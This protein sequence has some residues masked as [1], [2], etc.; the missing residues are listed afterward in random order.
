MTL[1]RAPPLAKVAAG[2]PAQRASAHGVQKRGPFGTGQG[3]GPIRCTAISRS[4]I[5]SHPSWMPIAAYMFGTKGSREGVERPREPEAGEAA[6]S[7][8]AGRG[9][10]KGD[11]GPHPP[12]TGA[13]PPPPPP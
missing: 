6:P 7:G 3:S 8:R 2:A 9:R 10:G 4:G 1:S 12:P 11:R 13:P 5:T